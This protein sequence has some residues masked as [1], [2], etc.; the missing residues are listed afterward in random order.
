MPKHHQ[1]S[2]ALTGL[3]LALAPLAASAGP[4]PLSYGGRLTGPTGS[5]LAGPVDLAVH[6]F[7]SETGGS[8]LLG[9]PVVVPAVTLQEGVFQLTLDLPVEDYSAI[10]PS[11][12]TAAYIEITDQTN[13]RTYPRQRFAVVPLAA[14]VPVDGSTVTFDESG[15]LTATLPTAGATTP[16]VIKATNAFVEVDAGGDITAIKQAQSFSGTLSG[17]VTG[18]QNATVVTKIRGKAFTDT[19]DASNDQKVIKWDNA[20]SSFKL[21][22]DVVSGGLS[23]GDVTS[24]IIADGTIVNADISASANIA[25]SKIGTGA[26]DN[27]HFNYLAG[28]TSDPQA[29]L[30]AKQAAITAATV[31]PVGSL[32]SDLQA[33]VTLDGYGS[34]AGQTGELRFEERDGLE[35][36]YVGLKAP[37]AVASNQ[38]WTLPAADGTAGQLLSTNGSGVLTW[39]TATT[40]SSSDTF[41]N[42]TINAD[43]NTISNI[44]DSEIKAGAN[45]A[46]AKLASG[47]ASH[48]LV[49]DGSGV[50]SSEA[51]LAISRGGT[52][53]ASASAALTNLLPSQTGNS[54]K[55]LSTDGTAASWTALST[56]N[57]NTAYDDRLK[58]DGGATGLVAATGRASLG[59]GTVATLDV[60]TAAD[61]VVQ[62]DATAKLPAVDGSAVSN[63]T[64]ANLSAAVAVAKGG[65]GATTADGALTSLLPAQTGNSGK[66]LSTNGSTTSWLALSATDWNTAY[67][68]RLQWDGGA[69]GLNATTARTSLG[70]G[71]AATLNVGTAASNVVQ[72]DG[73]AKLPA[74]DGSQL[75]GVVTTAAVD[76]AGAV[77]NGDFGSDGLMARTAAGT[78]SV[79]ADNS[80]NWNTAYTDRMKWDGGST[81]LVAA[82]ARTSLGLG[83]AATLD[84]G[85]TASKVVQL[86]GSA[87]LPAVD[88]S[89]LTN[90]PTAS[91][92][93]PTGYILV[94][95]N[96]SFTNA[97]FCVMKY[98]A[99]K[100]GTTGQAVSTSA[101]TPWVNVSWYEAQSA[102]KRVGGHLV[103]EGE[104]MTI[105]RN[106]EATAINDIDSAAGIQLATGHSDNSPASALAAVADPSLSSCTLTLELSNASNNSCALR[107]PGTNAGNSTD[108]GY[109]GTGNGYSTAYSAGAANKSQMRTHV[110]S[111]GNVIWDLA[112]N[113]W[114]W[115]DA[116]CDTTS[117]YTTGW[118]E[119]NNANV[120]DWE[121]LVA[122]P[123]GSLTS[124]NG[125]GQYYGCTASGNALLRGASWDDG[126]FAGVFAANLFYGPSSVRS[127]VGFRCAFSNAH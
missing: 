98:E 30:N 99:K 37:D 23:T 5:P 115:T 19:L 11:A 104:W 101:G 102:C 26:V 122:G 54:G 69:S 24:T 56:T 57:W 31:L 42:K 76:S 71:T 63:L 40:A 4:F 100:D 85:T 67:S 62:L 17:D 80:A 45:I 114:E 118:V 89:Q 7:R 81:G 61:Q 113:V 82:T 66:V 84:V 112:G 72:L 8:P 120:T 105:A 91:L 83:T 121:K 60:G 77:M 33:G 116:Q 15:R 13:A 27:T 47:T 117:W 14:R 34:G 38:I 10:F 74:V 73:T 12:E 119:W 44:E 75:T 49:N 127:D 29:Q 97:S 126:A 9:E 58:W 124:S 18:T 79:V 22:N 43:N 20:T 68:D 125:A 78:Y 16:G 86:D 59:L 53:A 39:A 93:C 103:N 55:V 35:N 32:T 109:Y 28:L 94:P 107:G 50:M 48:V 25:A 65:T 70:L 90:L 2:S 111:N 6:F 3:W 88:G 21:M 36:N 87:R 92:T 123:S 41:I 64:P 95:G 46:R 51:Q 96:A 110:L 1:L 52:G 106:I 108:Y